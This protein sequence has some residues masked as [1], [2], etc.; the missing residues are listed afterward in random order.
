MFA[1]ALV[2]I[3][4]LSLLL[5]AY[6]KLPAE[7]LS[8]GFYLFSIAVGFLIWKRKIK[9][10]RIEFCS[11]FSLVLYVQLIHISLLAQKSDEHLFIVRL[12][13]QPL[14]SDEKVLVL[15]LQFIMIIYIA[16]FIMKNTA[17]ISEANSRFSLDTMNTKFFDIDNKLTANEIT[18]NEATK[19]K[20]QVGTEADF[21]SEQKECFAVLFKCMT[22]FVVLTC[23][24]LASGIGMDI[25][26]RNESVKT[27]IFS[28]IPIVVG[29]SFPFIVLYVLFG[30]SVGIKKSL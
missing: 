7:I 10:N 14:E 2:I 13:Q 20:N 11:I 1:I 24:H 28:N 27:A 19:L 26:L 22:A 18:E 15:F 4:P 16:L 3:F 8:A 12:F 9:I 29:I 17:E 30:I 25:F 23:I 5:V 21:Y 6:P